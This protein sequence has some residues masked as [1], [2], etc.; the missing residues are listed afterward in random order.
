MT[1][2]VRAEV[3]VV[4]MSRRPVV[5]AQVWAWGLDIRGP[6][7]TGELRTG[8]ICSGGFWHVRYLQTPPDPVSVWRT[9]L[10]L[11]AGVLQLGEHED[12]LGRQPKQRVLAPPPSI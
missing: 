6:A 2:T 12:L 8:W 10:F 11:G 9:H 7:T 3:C 4:G 5:S 1:V